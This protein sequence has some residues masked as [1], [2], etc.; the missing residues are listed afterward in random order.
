MA[1]SSLMG[2]VS[3]VVPN[4]NYARY[5]PERFASIVAQGR[6]VR[7]L[8]FLDDASSDNSME[9]AE[10]LLAGLSISVTAQRNAVN[11]GSV[12]RQWA[13]GAEAAGT[14]FLWIA[15]AD[16]SAR[17]GMLDALAQ[18][19]ASDP[20]AAF[21]FSDSAAIDVDGVVTAESS[22]PYAAMMGDDL[23]K[24]DATLTGQ[25]FIGRCLCPRN[26]VVSA[27]AVLW[28]T[29]ALRAALE[30]LGDSIGRWR[31]AGD[32]RIYTEAARMHASI[33]YEARPFNLHR[34]HASSVTGS[35]P[36]VRH[37]AEVV[38]MHSTL[39]RL[40]DRKAEQ[41]EKMRHYLRDLR[42]AWNLG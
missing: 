9:V 3:V 38:A 35:I 11:S 27:S 20:S 28:R 19:L 40:L 32:W 1:A 22:K 26:L 12:F 7:H 21:A 39:R 34:R 5:L 15:E 42:H 24:G 25:E 23:L 29:E 17:P 8:T 30:S 2:S 14:P 6:I 37:F 16:D 10:P 31:C 13:R 36:V 33:H 18:R 4:Y 41:D